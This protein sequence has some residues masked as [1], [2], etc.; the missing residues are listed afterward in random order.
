MFEENIFGD[1]TLKL[2]LRYGDYTVSGF[3]RYSNL[4]SFDKLR[5]LLNA[6]ERMCY[7]S[8]KDD[9]R[10]IIQIPISEE[11][12]NGNIKLFVEWHPTNSYEIKAN[13]ENK[14]RF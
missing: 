8:K 12:Y 1:D 6:S 13:K 10:H 11:G 4:M 7:F 14:S 9:T 3:E 2:V 5:A